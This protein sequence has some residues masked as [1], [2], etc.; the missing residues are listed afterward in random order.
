MK[1]V[2]WNCP[3]LWGS[4]LFLRKYLKGHVSF[5][6]PLGSVETE[7]TNAL[8][9]TLSV[10]PILVLPACQSLSQ[11]V[12]L[13]VLAFCAILS[14][15]LK[16]IKTYSLR[17]QKT[18]SPKSRCWQSWFLLDA[19]RPTLSMPLFYLLVFSSNPW[20]VDISLQSL[21]VLTSPSPPHVFK[22]TIVI[23]FGVGFTTN[24]T[25][26]DLISRSWT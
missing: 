14:G 10:C 16:A 7:A 2:A 19:L 5:K 18:G 15:W 8:E 9:F 6:L 11:S 13:G 1:A 24:I 4:A 3:G 22:R 20:L 26:N 25:H 17:V 12:F 23:G 21:C